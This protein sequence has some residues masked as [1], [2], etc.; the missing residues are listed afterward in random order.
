MTYL[1]ALLPVRDGVACC[2]ALDRA[3]RDAAAAG[4]PR[5]RGQLMADTLV[6][7]ATGQPAQY[8]PPSA[9]P[10][11]TA[12]SST[13]SAVS[14]EPGQ[15]VE[16]HLVMTDRTLFAGGDE[17]ALLTGPQTS[18]SSPA[19]GLVPAPVARDL[20]RDAG[21]AWVRRL[22]T[23]PESGQLVAMESSR[24]VF[25]GHLRRMLTLRDRTCRTPWCEAP[26]RQGDHVVAH[27][28]G[29]PT[30]V[31][32]GQGLCERCN[33]T[34][35]LPGWSADVIEGGRDGPAARHVVRT[36]TPTGHAYDSTA[37]PLLG[38][39]STVPGV[40]P[41]CAASSSPGARRP[42]ARRLAPAG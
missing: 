6:S 5:S 32:N 39:P 23:D 12:G 38:P 1:T 14:R 9:S 20:V 34:K 40:V 21:R 15:T 16:I 13:A 28:D 19:G 37:P 33:Q 7:A 10:A 8:A 30:S 42:A 41:A 2:T 27:A 36:T 4:D 35:N 31:D 3:A 25:D 18:G 24:R 17:P 29:G 22:Y 11:P 26:I